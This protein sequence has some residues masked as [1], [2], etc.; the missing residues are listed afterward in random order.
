MTQEDM[1]QVK[2]VVFATIDSV[3]DG[4]IQPAKVLVLKA[5]LEKLLTIPQP[6]VVEGTDPTE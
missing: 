2:R 6:P 5:K 3:W 1:D 4:E